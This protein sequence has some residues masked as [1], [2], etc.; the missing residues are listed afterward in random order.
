MTT[1]FPPTL[2]VTKRS[3]GVTEQVDFFS[4]SVSP[5]E[6]SHDRG[7]GVPIAVYE[8][9]RVGKLVAMISVEEEIKS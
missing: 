4:A 1:N 7:T 6:A 5:D 2:Y 9:K 3:I 8:L